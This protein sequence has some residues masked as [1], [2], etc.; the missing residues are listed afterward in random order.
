M[1]KLIRIEKNTSIT[2]IEEKWEASA[3][4]ELI[5]EISKSSSFELFCE[6]IALGRLKDYK[7]LG[8]AITVKLHHAAVKIDCKG[9]ESLSKVDSLGL[10]DLTVKHIPEILCGIFG[11]Q[12]TYQAVEFVDFFSTEGIEGKKARS[13][14]G[15]TIWNAILKNDGVLGDGKRRY[16]FSRHDYRVPKKLGP[17][18]HLSFPESTVFRKNIIPIVKSLSSEQMET[19][20]KQELISTCLL[21]TSP[22]PRDRG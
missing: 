21:Y 16:L 10:V 6:G 7:L 5:V 1:A 14:I 20:D 18:S 12:L 11:M 13:L 17:L 4:T 15:S 19:N 3:G 22:S 2:D 8:C 9:V